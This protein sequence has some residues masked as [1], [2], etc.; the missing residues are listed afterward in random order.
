MSTG[1]GEGSSVAAKLEEVL[2]AV[3]DVESKVN[4]KLLAMKHEMESSDDRLVKRMHLD[5]KPSFCKRGHEKQHQFNEQVWE[6]YRSSWSSPPHGHGLRSMHSLVAVLQLA[7][8][9]WYP[10]MWVRGLDSLLCLTL[11]IISLAHASY[12]ENW[13][14]LERAVPCYRVALLLRAH[15][16]K[17]IDCSSI[18]CLG[19]KLG[20][21]LC[22]VI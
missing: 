16:L 1:T 3:R 18:S 22:S 8:S 13:D 17:F 15:N 10:S 19:W 6:P 7:C 11:P 9:G 4:D 5:T 14:I 2:Q 12:V 20:L 21:R